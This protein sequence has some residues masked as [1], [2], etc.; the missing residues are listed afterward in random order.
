MSIPNY[1]K[2]FLSGSKIEGETP[3][4][5]ADKIIQ[6]SEK[7][8]KWADEQKMEMSRELRITV[9]DIQT[10]ARLG[11][12]FGHKIRAATY[13]SLF[14]ESLQRDWYNKTIEEMNLSAGYWRHYAASGMAN[15]HNPLWTN[16]VGYVDFRE[17][18]D[19]S[20]FDVIANGGQVKLPSMSAT[21]GGVILE[22][23][24]ASFQVSVF[25]SELKGFTGKGYLETKVGDSRQNVKWSYNAPEA[26]KYILEFRYT[27]K[28]EQ[29]YNSPIEINGKEV[30]EIEFWKTGNPGAWVWERVTVDLNKG[31]NT[32]RIWP[33][34]W[35]VLDHLN[36]IK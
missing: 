9:E 36:V 14:R 35:V 3:L 10:I 18:F 27:L 34:G 4:Q 12:H 19:W 29:V 28:R 22:A 26:G 32:I 8:L 30:G 11:K 25:N 16:R 15:Y 13:L 23:E 5:V 24:D 31:E 6:N 17:N 20:V 7:A 1:T 2:A 33:E 21:S